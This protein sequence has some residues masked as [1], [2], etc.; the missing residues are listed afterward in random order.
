MSLHRY[1][2]KTLRDVAV[3]SPEELD[4]IRNLGKVSYSEIVEL[5]S[6]YGVNK[7]PFIKYIHR[8]DKE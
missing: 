2:L 3:V 5:L 1:G 4:K 8:N 7:E 6:K